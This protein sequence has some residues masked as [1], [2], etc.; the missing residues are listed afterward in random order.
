[1]DHDRTAR[2][3]A[4]YV[5]IAKAH[6]QIADEHA[7][8]IEDADAAGFSDGFTAGFAAGQ[9]YAKATKESEAATY[10]EGWFAGAQFER[11]HRHL[12]DIDSAA[13]ERLIERVAHD[14]AD[15][16]GAADDAAQA[17]A[18]VTETEPTPA[19]PT[20]RSDTAQDMA[21]QP[22]TADDLQ[23]ELYEAAARV[24]PAGTDPAT[25]V[26]FAHLHENLQDKPPH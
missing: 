25:I 1:M 8:A 21:R 16:T 15:T 26:L 4:I 10:L 12:C 7:G 19:D 6:Q 3:R 11:D 20:P 17:N 14:H 9:D 24:L 22:L 23:P 13:I 2:I 5:Q 18:A